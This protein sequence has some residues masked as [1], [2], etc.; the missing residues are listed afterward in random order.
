MS[1]SR[2][3]IESLPLADRIRERERLFDASIQRQ[4]R[5]VMRLTKANQ[6]SLSDNPVLDA[7]NRRLPNRP[8]VWQTP[9]V[10]TALSVPAIQRAVSLISSTVG[11]LSMQGYRSG[12]VMD[13]MEG[14]ADA[15]RLVV[16]PDPDETPYTFFST[17]AANMAKYGEVIWW[18]PTRDTDGLP[19][20]LVN[21]PLREV[22]VE[23]NWI[24]R[25]RPIYRWGTVEGTRYS[26]A[27]PEGRFVHIRYPLGEPYALRGEGPLQL[28][29][30]A[31]SVSVES[32]EWAA[33]F[34]GAGGFPREIVKWVNELNPTRTDDQG[35]PDPTGL[36]EAERFKTDYMYRDNN[37]P[38]IIDGRIESIAPIPVDPQGAQMLE[39]RLHQNGDAAR[40]FGLQGHFLEYVQRG[41][42]LTYQS[43][44]MAFTELVRTCLQPLYLEPFEQAMSDLLTRSTV[45]RFN[46]KGFLRADVKT[47]F[48]VYNIGIPLGIYDAAY[49]Q[50]EEGIL[51]GDVEFAPVPAAQ[52]GVIP[53]AIPNV[54]SVLSVRCPKCNKFLAR[55]L[56]PGSELD[57]PR[58]KAEVR[59]A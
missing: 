39:A 49:A 3:V 10:K 2:D 41:T 5:S 22:L 40:M 28:N 16:R 35:L 15:P 23:M 47:R 56:G 38:I 19:A 25:R 37:T 59:V 32:Q 14:R 27:N 52:P 43:L 45:A 20:A 8:K 12:I 1:L 29:A 46:T 57:C 6:K 55:S 21:V 13:G 58:C 34:Y 18:I 7:L 54:G 53:S 4:A 51:P 31:V 11:M 30:A 33:N 9:S 48:E 44:E 17:S 50:R 26:P 42:S 24:D 36:S